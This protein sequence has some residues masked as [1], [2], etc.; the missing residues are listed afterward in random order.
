MDETLKRIAERLSHRRK[1]LQQHFEGT[2]EWESTTAELLDRVL[3]LKE[4]LKKDV[5][6]DAQK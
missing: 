3:R 1:E 4:R 5:P 2:A 6:E